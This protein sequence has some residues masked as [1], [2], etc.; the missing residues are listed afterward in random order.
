VSI[1]PG[2][3]GGLY[4][5]LKAVAMRMAEDYAQNWIS[6]QVSTYLENLS[7][8]EKLDASTEYIAKFSHLLP[9]ELTEKS[10]ARIRANLPKFLEKHPHLIKQTRRVGH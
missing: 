8:D 9:S 6:S 10:A 3:E 7:T 2:N 4:A 1:G 5:A